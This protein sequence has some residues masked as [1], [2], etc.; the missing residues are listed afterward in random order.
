M[1]I[2]EKPNLINLGTSEKPIEVSKHLLYPDT[3]E[4][5]EEWQMIAEGSVVLPD[6]ALDKLLELTKK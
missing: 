4:G 1:S 3:A 5:Q 2:A 6:E